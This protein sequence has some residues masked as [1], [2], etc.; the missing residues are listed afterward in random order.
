MMKSEEFYHTFIRGKSVTGVNMYVDLIITRK[1][2]NERVT[3]FLWDYIWE[4]GKYYYFGNSD[5]DYN[6][7][8][9]I[10]GK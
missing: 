6:L 3:I 7:V 5:N 1:V 10:N 9:M 4:A 8:P 2:P